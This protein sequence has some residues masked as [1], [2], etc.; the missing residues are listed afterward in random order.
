MFLLL[1]LFGTYPC[2]SLLF[3]IPFIIMLPFMFQH[4]Y[5]DKV[6]GILPMCVGYDCSHNCLAV[7]LMILEHEESLL[8]ML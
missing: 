8:M 1:S 5:V 7:M 3:F 2:L 6:P 4:A